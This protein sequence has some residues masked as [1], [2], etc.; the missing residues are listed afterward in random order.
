MR[1]QPL[2]VEADDLLMVGDDAALE[3]GRAAGVRVDAVDADPGPSQ[4]LAQPAALGVLADDAADLD[5]RAETPQVVRDIGGPAE[6]LRLL[7]DLDDRHRRLGGDAP[8]HAGIVAVD[9]EI[10][11]HEDPGP[12]KG[13][14]AGA[15]AG[16]VGDVRGLGVMRQRSALLM[17]VP[18]RPRPVSRGQPPRRSSRGCRR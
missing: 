7:R 6:P 2:P 17:R 5:R 10:A 14:D 4:L 11:D 18:D 9:H 15:E 8:H 13:A 16:G 1:T 3:D 12:R